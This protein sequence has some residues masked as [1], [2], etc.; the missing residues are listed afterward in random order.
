ML[1]V[2]EVKSAYLVTVVSK[3]NLEVF[4]VLS[5]MSHCYLTVTSVKDLFRFCS[6]M[7]GL[8]SSTNHV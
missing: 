1:Y 8:L 5:Y 7:I 2:Y 3:Q 4:V 6:F